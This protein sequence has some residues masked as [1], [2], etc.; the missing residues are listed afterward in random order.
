MRRA[1]K[2]GE[3]VQASSGGQRRAAC[4]M[5][6]IRHVHDS[7]TK[8]EPVGPPA[9]EACIRGQDGAA[10]ERSPESVVR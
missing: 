5:Q 9:R 3:G 7:R 4:V 6:R 10:L 1:R 2:C 8:A